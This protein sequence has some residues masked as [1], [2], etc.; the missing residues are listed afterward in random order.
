MPHLV[1]VVFALMALAADP[2]TPAPAQAP[3]PADIISALETALADAIA[4]AEPSVVAIARYKDG[5]GDVTTA[6]RGMTPP[7]HEPDQQFPMGIRRGGLDE[8]IPDFYASDF[9]SGVVVGDR[10]EILTTAHAVKGASLLIVRAAGGQEFWAEV[11]ASDPR[12]DLAVIAPREGPGLRR[13]SLRPIKIG[14]PGILRKGTFLLALGNPFNAGRDGQASAS[15]GI[16]ANT[17]RRLNASPSETLQQ[18]QLRHYP[19]LYQLDAKLNL[20]MSGGAVVNLRGELVGL[21]TNAVNAGG[22]DAQA[23]YAI[24]IDPISARAIDLLRQ[25]K[26][27]EYGFL[28]IGL[29]E[30]RS[31][32]IQTVQPGTPAGEGGLLADDVVLSIGGLPVADADSLVM[33]V[34]AFPPDVPVKLRILRQGKEMEKTVVLSKL[35]MTGEVIVTNRPE[36]WRGLRVDYVSTLPNAP[37][38]LGVLDAMA[39]GGVRIADVQPGT[40]ADEVGLKSG[41]VIV[42]VEGKAVRTPSEFAKAVASLKGPVTLT[43]EADQTVTIPA[44]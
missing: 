35:P 8:A 2:P 28:G 18:N 33:S 25:G 10:N 13:P 3:S 20:G 4:K 1:P 40:G 5:K 14:A 29:S 16:L 30:D 42:A 23:G 9:A 39:R 24:P 15:W 6:V 43:L 41:Q 32:R 21:T 17:S 11:I 36:P 34:N 12:S 19:T 44:P 22:F 31:N 7:R 37:F 27:V 26:E 38:N